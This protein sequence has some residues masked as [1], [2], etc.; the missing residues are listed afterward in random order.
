MWKV[1]LVIDTDELSD[2]L[3]QEAR[4]EAL[5]ESVRT[6]AKCAA[7]GVVPSAVSSDRRSWTSAVEN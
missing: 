1:R 3:S 7:A 6:A 4:T 5:I 2:I